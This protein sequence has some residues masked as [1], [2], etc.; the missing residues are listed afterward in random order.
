MGFITKEG[1]LHQDQ[2]QLGR[3]INTNPGHANLNPRANRNT[4][5]PF[6][7]VTFLRT[8]RSNHARFG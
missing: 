3:I 2:S 7:P 4:T 1:P 8:D 6:V 5:V